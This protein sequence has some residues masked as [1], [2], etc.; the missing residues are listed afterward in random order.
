MEIKRDISNVLSN[1]KGKGYE[2][3]PTSKHRQADR[4][5]SEVVYHRVRANHE[6]Q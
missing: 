4:T 6:A 3:L 1:G 2:F 5:N